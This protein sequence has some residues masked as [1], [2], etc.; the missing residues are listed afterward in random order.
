MRDF[1][2]SAKRLAREDLLPVAH[3]ARLIPTGTDRGHASASALVRWII[4]G[5]GGVYLDGVRLGRG[6]LT[7]REALMRFAAGVSARLLE[8]EAPPV[9]AWEA[10]AEA[11]K[12]RLRKRGVKC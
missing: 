12:E 8:R 2:A 7:S 5:K 9:K 4:A 6:W 11:A 1:E 3:A 10:K